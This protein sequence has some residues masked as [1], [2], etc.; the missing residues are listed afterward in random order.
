[1]THWLRHATARLWITLVLGTVATLGLMT[2]L[3]PLLGL[4]AAPAV[5][6]VWMIA[7]F[8]VTGWAANRLG[9]WRVRRLLNAAELAERDGLSVTAEVLLNR[10]LAV[11]DSFLVSPAVRRRHLAALHAR[12]ARFHLTRPDGCGGREAFI[13]RYLAEVPDDEEVA[14]QWV[15]EIEQGGGLTEEDQGLA[16]HLAAAHPRHAGIQQ[17]LAR[18][19]LTQ[20]ST[21]YPALQCYRRVCARADAPDPGF[22]RAVAALL[23][24][25]GR[26]ED[27]ARQLV[28]RFFGAA[29]APPAPAAE[30]VADLLPPPAAVPGGR[31]AAAAA[32][33]PAE[34]DDEGLFRMSA[35]ADETDDDDETDTRPSLLAA[36]G[37]GIAVLR[38]RTVRL[39]AA[40]LRSSAG[41]LQRAARGM[42]VLCCA[43]RGRVVGLVGLGAVVLV[44]G[45]WLWGEGLHVL[46]GDGESPPAVAPPSAPAPLMMDRFT[47][48]VAAYLKAEHAVKFVESLKSRGLDAYSTETASGGKTWYQVRI[49]HFPDRQS[50]REL[51]SRLKQQ[52]VIEDFYVTH[53]TR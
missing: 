11:L 46:R 36:A 33:A 32:A 10:A 25:S 4:E 42:A 34:D 17:T 41:V 44:G 30:P 51:G 27:W 49:A 12:L 20:E 47:L 35:A 2:A 22:C 1:M 37:E 26:R 7:L 28:Q 3:Q 6:A 38:D 39:T 18:M 14:A 9:C 43:P 24:T 52:G 23:R 53:Y 5:A 45:L 50:A 16:A 31:V 13:R 40:T 21:D 19:H 29:S 15:L 8:W 48:Q